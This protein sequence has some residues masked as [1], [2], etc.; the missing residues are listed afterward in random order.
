MMRLFE[1][2]LRRAGVPLA[3]SHGYNPRPHLVFAFPLGVGIRAD[4]EWLDIETEAS[5]APEDLLRDLPAC[6]P[7]GVAV[8]SAVR[9]PDD[10]RSLMALVR[11]AVYR[12]EA[13]RRGRGRPDHGAEG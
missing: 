7:E 1:R 12:I 11:E 6:L 8:R 4:E 5:Y 9:A 10:R 2:A 3:Y 13:P